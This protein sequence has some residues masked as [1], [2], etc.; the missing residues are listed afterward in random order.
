VG[1]NEN[2]NLYTIFKRVY[3][4]GEKYI[5]KI[6]EILS[7]EHD[8]EFVVFEK[9][10]IK[11]LQNRLNVKLSYVSFNYLRI[12][13]LSNRIPYFRVFTRNYAMSNITKNYDLFINQENN[14]LVSSHAEESVYICQ[15]P[16]RKLKTS[17]P[18]KVTSKFLPIDVSLNTY[19]KIVTYSYY[20]KKY[21]EKWWNKKEIEVLYPPVDTE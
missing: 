14:T 16:T 3:G 19:D 7:K 20:N 13:N 2:W 18:L 5:C 21:I 11:Q 1:K 8:V 10:N 4:G 17:F 12:F 6:A 9:P 15:L